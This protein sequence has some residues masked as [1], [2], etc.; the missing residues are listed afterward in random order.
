MI[1][2]FKGRRALQRE[3]HL[4]LQQPGRPARVEGGRLA[5]ER[6]ERD[7]R[8]DD[9]AHPQ[10]DVA[11]HEAARLL[12]DQVEGRGERRRDA[13]RSIIYLSFQEKGK[14]KLWVVLTHVSVGLVGIHGDEA[15]DSQRTK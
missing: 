6:L 8:Q 12:W 5:P 15:D 9:A 14:Y 10:H 7:R 3:A 11:D 4:V 13:D 1:S 2:S